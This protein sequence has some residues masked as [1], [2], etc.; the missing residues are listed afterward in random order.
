[1]VSALTTGLV[2]AT[3]D[4]G[5]ATFRFLRPQDDVDEITRLLHEAYAPLA[6]AGMRF[7]ASHQTSEVTRRR[8]AGGDTIVAAIAGVVVGVVT[9][10][11]K[12][13]TSGG[14]FYD[15]PDVASF[16]QFAVSPDRQALGIGSALLD[17]V[18]ALAAERGASV[19]ALDTSEH[20]RDLIQFY[21]ARGFQ[22]VDHHRWPEVNYRSVRL[23]KVLRTPADGWLPRGPTI[24]PAVS[25]DADGIARVHAAARRQVYADVLDPRDLSSATLAQRVEGWRR[26]IDAGEPPLVFVA[27]ELGGTVGFVSGGRNRHPDF[28]FDAEVQTLY[29]A[30][31]WQ[32]RGVGRRLMRA[33]VTALERQD[34]LSLVVNVFERNE[35]GC[36]FYEALG[37][38]VVSRRMHQAAHGTYPGVFYGWTS[39][40]DVRA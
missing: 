40:A 20:A 2:K 29:V 28:P 35:A 26:Q 17:M 4:D 22:F 24:R 13:H 34:C 10:Y 21:V 23:A 5:A 16:G 25:G 33:I 8:F 39:L 1:M 19:L 15:R 30:P 27:A 32:H 9:L 12:E 7:V 37:G 3:A 11:T 14:A 31:A 38:R 6:A 18:E 36:R